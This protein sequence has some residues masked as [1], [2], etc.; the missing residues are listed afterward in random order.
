MK[1]AFIPKAD[2]KVG[3]VIEVHGGKAIITSVKPIVAVPLTGS[4]Q[5]IVC[6][7]TDAEPIAEEVTI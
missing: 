2:Y 3:Q 7:A 6:V 1:F 4:V 5:R